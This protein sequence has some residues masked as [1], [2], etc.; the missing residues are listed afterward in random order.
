MNRGRAGVLAFLATG[1]VVAGAA[2]DN[3]VVRATEGH[4]HARRAVYAV[5]D[6]ATRILRHGFAATGRCGVERWP[7]KTLASS[8]PASA[9]LLVEPA[10]PT[11]IPA[12]RLL[13]VPTDR[14][15][16]SPP[17]RERLY[18]PE[19]VVYRLRGVYLVA[20]K[21]ELDSDIHLEVESALDG[22]TMIAEIPDPGCVKNPAAKARV[23]QARSAFVRQVGTP[24]SYYTFLRRRVSLT[25]PG[26]FDFVHGQKG[27]A[28]N[29]IELHPVLAFRT[30]SGT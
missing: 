12:L 24:T 14:A 30:L 6:E 4:P 10:H 3:V 13:P 25:G 8:D 5:E 19:Q 11:T 20:Y 16:H 7:E 15:G 21:L 27:V 29:G 1:F 17:E 26:F 22:S 28:P 2:I 9:S 18:G 23:A